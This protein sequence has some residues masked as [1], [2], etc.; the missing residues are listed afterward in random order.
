MV[1]SPN[2]AR[3]PRRALGLVTILLLGCGGVAQETRAPAPEPAPRPT[4]DAHADDLRYLTWCLRE[5][6]SWREMREDQGLD[7]DALEAEALAISRNEVGERGFLRGL[8][9]YISGISDGHG[10]AVLEGVDLLELRRWPFSLIQVEEGVMVDGVDPATF[11]SKAL[12]RGDLILAIDGQP[13]EDLIREQERFVIAS[14]PSARRRKA[15]LD[16]TGSSVNESMQVLV[17][18]LGAA[19]ETL[20]EVPCPL[21]A[22]PVARYGWRHFEERFEQ[23][24]EHTAYFCVGN[25]SPTDPAFKTVEPEERD[26]ILAHQYEG[27]DRAFEDIASKAALILDLRGNPGGTDLLGQALALHL[28]E[29]GFRYFGLSAKRAGEWHRSGWSIPEV[30]TGR[31]RFKGQLVCLIDEKTFSVA[32]NIA[33]CLRDQHPNV[34]FVGQPTGGGSGAPRV[35]TLPA[36]KAR[37]SFCTMRVYAPNGT[38]IEG[39]GVQPELLVR[40][41]RDQMLAGDD[42]VLEAALATLKR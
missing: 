10:G 9:R 29:P 25:F 38:Y 42:A 41:T 37:V 26:R 16:L 7:L 35:F 20:V 23:L 22:E 11:R 17:A 1:T 12:K 14:T 18:P 31:P 34:R 4:G 5:N 15:I 39:N 19:N 13:I 3:F 30:G 33:A 36:T 8:R 24:D 2:Q 27:Y 6:W 28:M 32:D 21:R 40:P